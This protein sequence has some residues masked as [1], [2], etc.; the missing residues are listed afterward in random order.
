MLEDDLKCDILALTEHW[1]NE[2]DLNSLSST[3]D[4]YSLI[5]S[6]CRS[7]IKHGGSALF[8]TKTL[9]CIENTNLTSLSVERYLEISAADII[10]YNFTV[11]CIYRTNLI[12]DDEFLDHLERLLD[13]ISELGLD[14]L[15]VGDHNIDC[16]GSQTP[17]LNRL[18]DIL[19]IHNFTNLT[20]FPTR[21]T[22]HS[23]TAL[24]H[25]YSNLASDEVH[26]EP[27][28][29]NLSD[30]RAVR[31][32]VQRERPLDYQCVARVGRQYGALNR[33][34]F[35][36]S[37]LAIDWEEVRSRCPH[38]SSA[39]CLTTSVIKLISNSFEICF[40]LK[41]LNPP[42][43]Q[44]WICQDIKNIKNLLFDLIELTDG[45]DCTVLSDIIDRL[46]LKY[47]IMLQN[48]KLTY[49]TNIINNN[50]NVSKAMW[51]VV[52]KERGKNAKH[53][54][55]FTDVVRDS[56]GD[57]FQSKLDAV[58]AMNSRFCG[59]AAAC[60]APPADLRAACAALALARPPS[61]RSLRL[62]PLTPPEVH[63]IVTVRIPRKTS[64]D[65][66]NISMDLL[67]LGAAPLAPLLSDV[68]NRCLIEGAYPAPLKLSKIS[69]IFKGK[70]KRELIDGYR[71]VAVIPAVAKVFENGLSSRIVDYL[72]STSALSDRQYA[73]RAGR[74]T[75]ALAREVTRRIVGAREQKLQVAV[76]FCDLSKAFDVADHSVLAAKLHHYG[77]AGAPHSLLTDFMVGRSQIVAGDGGSVRSDPIGTTMGVAQGSSLSNILFSLLLNDL[78]Q[79]VNTAEVLMYADDVAAVVTA[80]SI[81]KLEQRLNDTAAVLSDWFSRNGLALNLKKTQFIHFYF[82]GR[83][84]RALS[85]LVDGVLIDQVQ[86]TTFLGFELDRGLTWANHIHKLCGRLGAACFALSRLARTVPTDVVRSCYFATVHSL[87]QYGTELWGRA[88]DWERVF[89]MQKRAVRIIARVTRCTHAR[90]HFKALGI[91]TLPS[92]L[93]FQI[94]VY[95]REN[96]NSFSAHAD[97]HRYSTRAAAANKLVAVARSSAKAAKQTQVAGPTIYNRLPESIT[98]APNTTI[99]KSRLKRWLVEQTFYHFNE[100]TQCV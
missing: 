72:S 61:D 60:G 36:A 20:N 6:Y 59:A 76:L 4:G 28:I 50:S 23:S 5:S 85:T 99:F 29:T 94:A 24:D 95:V 62:R 57:K 71:P 70:G 43:K 42:R 93:I 48:K 66:Y 41:K 34:N 63:R 45:Q 91:M 90:P 47:D 77:I 49:Y 22:S 64:K 52:N 7:N 68:Y 89:R 54:I 53:S 13:K 97:V 86:V 73:Y 51:S 40:P 3:F 19:A 14:C 26:A 11:I 98:S 96:L 56:A 58:N 10:S 87:L 69:P 79:A 82:G 88:A 16:I 31:A 38:N 44:N 80:P 9:K 30:H 21:V 17:N 75:T 83:Q 27:I 8:V 100:F 84:P 67:H 55:D 15:I 65:V 33:D 1:L 78:P 92:I 32:R 2:T 46:N 74:S 12:N 18:H 81:D 35:I 39:E 37:I 25:V